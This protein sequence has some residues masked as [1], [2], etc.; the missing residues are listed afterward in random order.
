MSKQRKCQ[1]LFLGRE[2]HALDTGKLRKLMDKYNFDIK[3]HSNYKE[4]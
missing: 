4:F 2:V 3:E 1:R